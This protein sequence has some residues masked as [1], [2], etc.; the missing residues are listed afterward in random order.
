[1]RRNHSIVVEFDIVFDVVFFDVKPV[2]H[3]AH[4]EVTF[5]FLV[6]MVVRRR[7]ESQSE[8]VVVVM[9]QRRR[10]NLSEGV[11]GVVV[12][13]RRHESQSGGGVVRVVVMRMQ[14]VVEVC[15]VVLYVWSKTNTF[16][17][18]SFAYMETKT[19]LLYNF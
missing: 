4:V 14:M 2:K 13:Q 10:E 19:C 3:V 7:C 11:V 1:V 12:V 15:R 8:G 16:K 18:F 17:Y 5:S 9:V 6:V